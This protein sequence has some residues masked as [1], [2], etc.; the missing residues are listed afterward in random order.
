MLYQDAVYFHTTY[1]IALVLLV[2]NVAILMAI[3]CTLQSKR[4]FS[5]T[6][7]QTKKQQRGL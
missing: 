4:K 6:R 2:F 5:R 7:Q 1:I 3:G